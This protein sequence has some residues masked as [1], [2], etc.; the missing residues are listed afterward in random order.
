MGVLDQTVLLLAQTAPPD[1]VDVRILE[2]SSA[3]EKFLPALGPLV[4]ALVGGIG[5]V[6][7]GGRMQRTTMER[8]EADR[9]D[10]EDERERQR[11]ERERNLENE[12][13]ERADRA[14]MR[15]AVGILHVV[16]ARLLM[17]RRLMGVFLQTQGF[18]R[19]PL[20]TEIFTADEARVLASRMTPEGWFTLSQAT[21][22]LLVLRM[23]GTDTAPTSS[24]LRQVKSLFGSTEGI[25]GVVGDEL[26][27]LL[28]ALGDEQSAAFLLGADTFD[29]PAFHDDDPVTGDVDSA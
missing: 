21:S 7:I 19:E 3:W 14:A 4:G 25:I 15:Q 6:V 11:A 22:V 13:E 1:A 18:L 10:R 26:R 27:T 24:R 23:I 9:H 17:L 12:R 29:I 20:P 5:G 2:D 8:V 16:A 28:R